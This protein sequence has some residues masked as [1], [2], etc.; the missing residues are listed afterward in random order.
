MHSVVARCV[1]D[2]LQGPQ[3]LDGLRVDP[4]HVEVAELMVHHEL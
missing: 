2:V 4:E 1:Q 3:A